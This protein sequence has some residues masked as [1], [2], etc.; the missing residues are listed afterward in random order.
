MQYCRKPHGSILFLLFIEMSPVQSKYEKL[1]DIDDSA[2]DCT[3][4]TKLTWS[5]CLNKD[6]HKEI[7]PKKENEQYIPINSSMFLR[8][9][10][11]INAI[12]KSMTVDIGLSLY[13]V[14]NRIQK[15]FT[16]YNMNT[17]KMGKAGTMPLPIEKLNDIWRPDLYIFDMAY[18]ESYKVNALTDSISILY[19]YYWNVSSYHREYTLNNTVIQYYLDARAKIY[20]F[21]FGF[22]KFPMEENT[23]T[24]VLGTAM[25]FANF[26]WFYDEDN[27][28]YDS[29]DRNKIINGYKVTNISWINKRPN[30][31]N[32]NYYGMGTAIGFKVSMT[33]QLMPFFIEYYIPCV[34]IVF[35]THISFIIPLSAIPGRIALL[36]TEFLTL[37]NLFIYQQVISKAH[38]YC[39]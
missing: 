20:C 26:A 38:Q 33:R 22:E 18:F 35:L 12:D 14:D 7:S 6:Y 15:K 5:V 39:N 28:R 36:V 13:W 21:K 24:F 4:G 30:D 19:N 27:W 34:A 25:T 16:K 11:E 29:V 32:E 1:L 10:Q 17:H 23:C 37:T 8:N 3:N 31:L 9:I 2:L